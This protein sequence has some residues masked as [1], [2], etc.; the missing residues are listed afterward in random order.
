MKNQNY[1]IEKPNYCHSFTLKTKILTIF[2]L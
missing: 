2:D 1:D